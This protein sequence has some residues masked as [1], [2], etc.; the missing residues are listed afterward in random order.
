MWFISFLKWWFG[1]GY[2]PVV[3]RTETESETTAGLGLALRWVLTAFL[4]AV[5]FLQL[6]R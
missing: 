4:V 1:I 2:S 5:F 3:G 6:L